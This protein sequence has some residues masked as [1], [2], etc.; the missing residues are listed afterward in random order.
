M[1]RR[2]DAVAEASLYGL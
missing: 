1:Q 2:G